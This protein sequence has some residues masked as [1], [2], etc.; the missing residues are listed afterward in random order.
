[1]VAQTSD[2]KTFTDFVASSESKLRHSL[3]AAFGGE[4]GRDAAADALEY[5]WK[6]WDRV[7]A[8]ENPVGYLYTMMNARTDWRFRT[9]EEPGLNGRALDYP[10]GKVLGGCSSINGMIYMRGQARDYDGWRQLGATG[11]A[12]DDV[13]PYFRKTEDFQA[14]A[15]DMHGAGG[16]W[17]VEEPRLSWEI[18]DAFRDAAVEA[19]IPAT[20]DFNRGDNEGV[21]YFHVNQRKGVRWNAS[22]AFLRPIASR[23]NL[24]VV[25][26][27]HAEKLEISEGRV[28]A[29]LYRQG[30]RPVRAEVAGE[31]V[32]AAGSIGLFSAVNIS[33]AVWLETKR[34]S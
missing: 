11:W 4:V 26:S 21:G 22:K 24:T 29:V 7:S 5:A 13:L 31:A 19:G 9:V 25:T 23:Q 12:W 15:D 1:M 16:E 27:A 30:D 20:E 34:Q 8:M 2:T 32:L 17:R 6:H 33:S 28:T 18:L 14:G 3:M 10:R